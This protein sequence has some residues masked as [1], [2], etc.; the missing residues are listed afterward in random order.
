MYATPY[1][2]PSLYGSGLH[3]PSGGARASSLA[4]RREEDRIRMLREDD[5]VTA[6]MH[7]AGE[8]CPVCNPPTLTLFNNAHCVHRTSVP[9]LPG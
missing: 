8:E 3:S 1:N 7:A 2:P 4:L 6:A 9:P 5:R